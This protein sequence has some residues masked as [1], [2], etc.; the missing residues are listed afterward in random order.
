ML[1]RIRALYEDYTAEFQR[2]EEGRRVG[3]GMFGMTNGPRNYPC[4]ERFG[5]E[6]EGLLK[7]TASAGISQEEIGQIL[8]YIYFAPQGRAERQDAVYWMLA[9]VHGMTLELIGQLA[10][11]G[12]A[13]LLARYEAAY[14]RRERLPAQKRAASALRKR[15]RTGA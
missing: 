9:A 2:L 4:H 13:R 5:R 6:L 3:A 11:E 14:P 12:A 7:E 10:P 1:D 15:E 8:E